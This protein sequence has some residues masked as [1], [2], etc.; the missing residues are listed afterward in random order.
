MTS[1]TKPTDQI[2][3]SSRPLLRETPQERLANAVNV[4]RQL[5]VDAKQARRVGIDAEEQNLR[6]CLTVRSAFAAFVDFNAWYSTHEDTRPKGK[7]LIL[8]VGQSLRIVQ[9][10][11]HQP[12]EDYEQSIAEKLEYL[13]S[14]RKGKRLYELVSG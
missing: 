3:S 1:P 14:M 10:S 4:L 12:S 5:V 8:L 6:F 7:E 9:G 2:Q 13:R 11:K